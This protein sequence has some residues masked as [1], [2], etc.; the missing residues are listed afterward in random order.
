MS[1]VFKEL[2][3]FIGLLIFL[4][5]GMHMT[6]WMT[7]PAEHFSNLSDS[8]FGLFHPLYF[9]ALVYVVLYI[10]RAILRGIKNLFTRKS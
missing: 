5:L 1:K 8:S 2:V 9:T 6:Q 4:S 7:S 10:V 3:I